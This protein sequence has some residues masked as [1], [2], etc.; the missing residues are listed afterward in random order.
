MDQYQYPTN[1]F[2]RNYANIPYGQ[3]DEGENQYL[4]EVCSDGCLAYSITQETNLVANA[5]S[6]G[7][8]E[9]GWNNVASWRNDW[10]G[11]NKNNLNSIHYD[12]ITNQL[13]SLS[14][15]HSIRCAW[16]VRETEQSRRL[17]VPPWGL[18]TKSR[19]RGAVMWIWQRAQMIWIKSTGTIWYI[20][21]RILHRVLPYMTSAK[22]SDFSTP[23]PLVRVR[24]WFVLKIH[25]TSLTSSAFFVTLLHPLEFAL[26]IWSPLSFLTVTAWLSYFPFFPLLGEILRLPRG[27][28]RWRRRRRPPL[29]S[30][31]KAPS[32]DCIKSHKWLDQRERRRNSLHSIR[33]IGKD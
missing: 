3:K 17:M 20:L 7:S 27:G 16:R 29:G 1:F 4:E 15:V 24:N 33:L 23:I 11:Q 21:P 2:I 31:K 30:A 32:G 10:Y 22:Y 28:G 18:I 9:N 19:K 26:Q 12:C 13:E 8:E 6:G 5:Y 25:T 14:N